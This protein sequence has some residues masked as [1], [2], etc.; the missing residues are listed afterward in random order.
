MRRR[1]AVML[2]AISAPKETEITAAKNNSTP[3]RTRSWL[4]MNIS[5]AVIHT[6]S[7]VRPA[8]RT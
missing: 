6:F 2:F 4:L 7:R 3:A 1:E 5:C 8:A